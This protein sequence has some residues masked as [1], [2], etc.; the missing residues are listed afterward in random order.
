MPFIIETWDKP[1]HQWLRKRE[2]GEHL[3]FL[4]ANAS[5][6]LA[7]GAKLHDDGTDAGGGVYIYDSDDR[8]EADRFIAGDPFNVAGLFDRVLLTRMRKA[9][10]DGK[11]FIAP[12]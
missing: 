3:R 8:S 6:L 9:Y 4:E 5:R 11:C 12:S 2:R 1:D 7:C 10:V